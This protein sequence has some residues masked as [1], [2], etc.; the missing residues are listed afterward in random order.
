[1]TAKSEALGAKLRALRLEVCP[2]EK[3]EDFAARAGIHSTT[4]SRIEC[5]HT[6]PGV[7]TLARLARCLGVP[8]AR[9]L[10]GIED[11]E[12]GEDPKKAS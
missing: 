10:E 5:G 3:A 9:L 7:D 1:M 11:G 6:R 12:D 2:K 4:L 8:L